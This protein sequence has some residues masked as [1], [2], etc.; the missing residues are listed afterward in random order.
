MTGKDTRK[1]NKANKQNYKNNLLP[2]DKRTL[3]DNSPDSSSSETDTKNTSGQSGVA[4]RPP[5]ANNKKLRT[6]NDDKDMDQDFATNPNNSEQFFDAKNT[7][8]IDANSGSTTAAA[9]GFGS[10]APGSPPASV[11]NRSNLD[12]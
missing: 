3:S 7:L 9:A 8:P 12:R 6:F 2:T 4:N 1:R 5:G 10:T 11:F